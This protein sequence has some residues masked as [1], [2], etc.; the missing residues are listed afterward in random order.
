MHPSSGLAACARTGET[1]E[2]ASQSRRRE[3]QQPTTAQNISHEGILHSSRKKAGTSG[4]YPNGVSSPSPELVAIGDL[5]WVRTPS[6]EHFSTPTGL[7]RL[8]HQQRDP[9]V[10][11]HSHYRTRVARLRRATLGC[12]SKPYRG[13]TQRKRINRGET[14]GMNKRD[15]RRV[16]RTV[17][18]TTPRSRSSLVLLIPLSVVN[19]IPIFA[20]ANH[21]IKGL[22]ELGFVRQ[23]KLAMMGQLD[24]KPAHASWASGGFSKLGSRNRS[25][26]TVR[27]DACALDLM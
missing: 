20:D 16:V 17:R 3:Q 12:G 6:S 7:R 8:W 2:T 15:K 1:A 19:H 14:A 18:F 5:P 10:R 4:L 27:I 24:D 13:T 23:A 11:L 26:S 21:R 9:W 25:D 22:G